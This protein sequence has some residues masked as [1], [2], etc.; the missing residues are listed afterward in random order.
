MKLI[1]KIMNI[2]IV[3]AMQNI[4]AFSRGDCS[5]IADKIWNSQKIRKSYL[6]TN[7]LLPLKTTLGSTLLKLLSISTPS[8]PY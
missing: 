3:N 4:T 1:C 8:S 7:F 2:T 6:I 5:I